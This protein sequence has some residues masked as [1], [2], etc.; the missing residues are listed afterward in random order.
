MDNQLAKLLEER[1][2]IVFHDINLQSKPL[3]ILLM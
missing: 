2:G 1:F 3:P